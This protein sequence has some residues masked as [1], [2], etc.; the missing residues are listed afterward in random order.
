MT[1]QKIKSIT[2]AFSMQPAYFQ[3]YEVRGN[4]T[5][6]LPSL[7][8]EIKLEAQ[9]SAYTNEPEYYYIGYNFYGNLLFK[10]LAKTVNVQYFT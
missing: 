1:T 3:V 8:A 5:S 4:E 7:I 6:F 9:E 2:E 10:Y